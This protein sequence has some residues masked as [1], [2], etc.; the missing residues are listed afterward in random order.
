MDKF[1]KALKPNIWKLILPVGYYLIGVYVYLTYSH[2]FWGGQMRLI[3]D[4]FRKP[5]LALIFVGLYLFGSLVHYVVLVVK[6]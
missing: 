1:K 3:S 6:K 2:S 5:D 4:V